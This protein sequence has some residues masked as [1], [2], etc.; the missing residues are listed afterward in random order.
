[1]IE[2]AP[3]TYSKYVVMERNKK[4]LYVVVLKAIYGMLEASLLWYH[5]LSRK[6][7]SIGFVFNP[8]D[9]CVCNRIVNKKQHT[10]RFHMDD[11]LSSHLDAT[12]NDEF[13][14]WLDSTFG[15]LKKVTVSRGKKHTFLGMDLDFSDKGKLHISQLN[16]VSDM[17]S[18]CPI[19]IQKDGTAPNC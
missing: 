13:H 18:A 4:V 3:E 10:V 6:L 5:E 11:I 14:K 9:A 12:F 7:K 1:M 19:K 2:I 8:Y 15:E 16:H 17:I